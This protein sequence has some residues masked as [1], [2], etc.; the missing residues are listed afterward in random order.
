VFG[1][2]EVCT[3][4]AVFPAGELAGR[5][6]RDVEGGAPLAAGQDAEMK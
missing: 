5:S 1:Q 6:M 2:L 3:T 4:V